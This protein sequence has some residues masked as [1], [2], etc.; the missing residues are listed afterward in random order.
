LECFHPP[1]GGVVIVEHR[2]RHHCRVKKGYIA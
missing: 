1:F 2:K